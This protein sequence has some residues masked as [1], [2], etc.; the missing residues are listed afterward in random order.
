MTT[1]AQHQRYNLSEKGRARYQRYEDTHIRFSVGYGVTWVS[2]KM[3]PW[4][5]EILL[6]KYLAFCGEQREETRLIEEQLQEELT[7]RS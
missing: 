5:K 2:R 4:M 6:A 1:K 7:R 3:E